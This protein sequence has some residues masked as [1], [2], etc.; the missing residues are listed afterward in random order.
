MCAGGDGHGGAAA[1]AG[2]HK[3][4]GTISTNTT[5]SPQTRRS[6]SSLRGDHRSEHLID[7][8]PG[9]TTKPCQRRRPKVQAPSP[10]PAPRASRSP[11]PPSETTGRRGQQRGRRDP[12]PDRAVELE[13]TA[14]G[15]P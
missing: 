5:W 10:P 4:C 3:E 14:S 1:T 2:T 11:S 13:S 15:K 9:T 7:D 6:I 12:A 8:L